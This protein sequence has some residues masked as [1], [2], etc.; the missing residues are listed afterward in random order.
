MLCFVSKGCLSEV[1]IVLPEKSVLNTTFTKVNA[2]S[3]FFTHVRLS[4]EISGIISQSS[5]P[6]VFGKIC[7]SV[8]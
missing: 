2:T 7:V 5:Y 4:V 8:F 1:I 6:T 3:Y